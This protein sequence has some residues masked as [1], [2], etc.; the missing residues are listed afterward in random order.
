MFARNLKS[1]VGRNPGVSTRSFAAG[2]KKQEG[3]SVVIVGAKRTA[4]GCFMGQLSNI[5]APMLGS[6]AARGAIEQAGI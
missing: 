1:V 2:Y 6:T 3:K 4:I 5:P